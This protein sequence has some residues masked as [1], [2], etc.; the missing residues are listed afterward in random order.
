MS[1]GYDNINTFNTISKDS[2]AQWRFATLA[3]L[4]EKIVHAK[5]LATIWGIKDPHTLNVTLSRYVKRGLLIRLQKGMYSLKPAAKLDARLIG[6]KALHGRAYVST[7]TVLADAGVIM[8]SINTITLISSVSK[9]FTVAGH[10]Y[11]SRQLKDEALYQDLGLVERDGILVASTERAI[12]DMLYF[13]PKY[14]FDNPKI[15]DWGKVHALQK[16]LGYTL[17]GNTKKL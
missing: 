4:D 10:N 9:N 17:I 13:N 11:K 8:Q 6:I 2:T 15:V 3:R 16:Q 12:A 14:Y 5:D 1:I 7:E